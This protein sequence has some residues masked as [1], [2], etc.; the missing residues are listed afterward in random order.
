MKK[1]DIVAGGVYLVRAGGRTARVRVDA[2]RVVNRFVIA[3]FS[4][5]PVPGPDR[6]VY[7][8]TDMGTGDP[9]LIRSPARFLAREA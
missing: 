3:L 6:V 1:R 5:R 4:G 9:D 2:V 7:D 8:V